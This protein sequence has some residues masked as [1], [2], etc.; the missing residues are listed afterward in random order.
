MLAKNRISVGEPETTSTPAEEEP[1]GSD[2]KPE[3]QQQSGGA[4][5][6][7]PADMYYNYE[8]LCSRATV[9]PDSEIPQN[10]LIL[11]HS[12]GYDSRRRSNLK[13]LDEST[14][15][16][17]AGNLLVLLDV[18][19]RKQ[20]YLRSFSGGGIGAMAVH[21]TREFF[22][23]AE[24]GAQ[25]NIVVYEYPSLRPY[26]LLRGG[27]ESEYKSVDFNLDGSLLASAGGAP[28]HRLTLWKWRQEKVMLVSEAMFQEIYRVSFSPYNPALLVSSG[29][30]HIKFWKMATTFTVVKLQGVIG[31]F[32]KTAATDI[33][34]Y[35]ELPDGKVVSG[36]GWGNLLLWERSTIWAEICR[37]EGGK[38]H[39]GT[40]Q[41]F[42][43]EDGQLMTF[44]SDGAIR[45]WDSELINSAD[46]NGD[47]GTFEMEP[48]NELVV[49]HN[50]CLVSV[51]R[52]AQ[53]D[54]IY[55]A[56][57]SNGAIWKLDLSFSATAADPECLFS[58]HSGAIQGLD[59]SKKSHLMAT[60]TLDRSV[61]VFDFLSQRELIAT[62]FNQGGTALSWA[63]PLVSQSGGL[64]VTGFEDGVVR[65]LELYDPQ[66]LGGATDRSPH[67]EAALRLRQAFKP[68]SAAVT[69]VAFD[70]SGEILATGSSDC[71]IF[72]FAV[73]EK[74]SPVGFVRVPGPVRALEWSPHSHRENRLLILCGSGDVV[75]VPGPDAGA[76]KSSKTF[77][78][79]HLPR[80]S[81]RF[82]SIK[83]RIKREEE[84][85]RREAVKKKKEEEKELP[86]IHIPNPPSPLC[87]GF[88]SQPGQFWLS[89][90]G[91]DA[92][93]LY[94]CK[95]SE[96]QEDD[97]LQRQDEPF[98]FRH[99]N[100]A[101][102]D[103]I[104]F[105]TFS[106]NRQLLLCGMQSGSIR[107]YPLQ[108]EDHSL[109]SMQAYWALS[110]HDN[111]YGHVSHVRCSVDDLFVLTGGGD[112]NIF[113]FCLLSP[114]EQKETLER[115]AQIPSPRVGLE[116]EPL[117]L[118][119]EDP[120]AYS[121][122]EAKQEA[123][124]DDQRRAAELKE[125]E[126]QR[127]LAELQRR[128]KKV[129]SVNQSLA[130]H[131]WLKAQE[132]LL[133][134]CFYKLEE[135]KSMKVMEVQ[136]QMAGE[137]ERHSITKLQEWFKGSLPTETV[138]VVGIISD[139]RVSNY[140][141]SE[142][143]SENEPPIRTEPDGGEEAAE[144]KRKPV[145]QPSPEGHQSEVETMLLPAV[146]PKARIKLADRQE[147]KL[148]QAAEQAEQAWANIE[149][150]R[151]EL[152]QIIA[153]KPEENATDSQ[154][155]QDIEEAKEG[156]QYFLKPEE[157]RKEAHEKKEGMNQRIL[158]LRDVKVQL[159]AQAQHLQEVQQG[160]LAHLC[161]TPPWWPKMLPEETPEKQL[162]LSQASLER[163]QTLRAQRMECADQ[164]E[165][166]DYLDSLEE[167][168]R[169]TKLKEE[170][171][172]VREEERSS[173]VA[174]EA[175]DDQETQEELTELE[176]EQQEEEDVQLLV[177]QN[178]LIQQMEILVGRFEEEL[179][180]L[181]CHKLHL[182]NWLKWTDLQ[183]LMLLQE[184]R[185]LQPL[186]EEEKTLQE[187]INSFTQEENNLTPKLEENKE[188]LELKRSRITKLKETKE[189]LTSEFKAS[190]GEAHLFR[191]FLISVFRKKV[192][193]EE[194][195]EGDEGE[196]ENDEDDDSDWGDYGDDDDDDDDDSDSM[197][198]GLCPKGCNLQLFENTL[199]LRQR[200][201]DVKQ[202]LAEEERAAAALK[203]ETNLLMRKAS[204]IKRQR[205]E[206]A[207]RLELLGNEKKQKIKDLDMMVPLKLKQIKFLS[208]GSI[209]S[210][211]SEAL[212]LDRTRQPLEVEN[213]Q[214]KDQQHQA[215][216]EQKR[217]IVDRRDMIA[218][219]KELEV[220]CNELQMGRF[221][222]PVDVETLQMLTGCRREEE[223][224]Q[225]KLL[226]EAAQA[227]EMK[228]WDE[229]FEEAMEALSAL[230]ET[231]VERL[232]GMTILNEQ[233][234]DLDLRFDA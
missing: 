22:C 164:G 5:Q 49:G 48:I 208:D 227:E 14:L 97:P 114:E 156:I 18:S 197:D 15:M 51:V 9:T 150:R 31:N 75:E 163:Y 226:L 16:F 121:L 195:K 160:R 65:L 141:L 182:D 82:R 94:H 44:G 20:R 133:D 3:T 212:V 68:H 218:C 7:L 109:T 187:K 217:L 228:L 84:I 210:D 32:G 29:S 79:H 194:E 123:K 73:G 196:E 167:L 145:N 56:Q 33:E 158:A 95:L 64:L 106:S 129:L 202:Q 229:K 219:I 225:E 221:G 137:Q 88:Y 233:R 231:N 43:L 204:E 63:P 98:A 58:F 230:M 74:Y 120:T 185:L 66:K 91:F 6:E 191:D 142:F 42:T 11:S 157:M 170:K 26:R 55:F 62:R 181:L 232:Y 52:S 205:Q 59:V 130:E 115:K 199:Q 118:D 186:Q 25:P 85:T 189:A 171:D 28:D 161:Q 77:E 183:L 93:F 128:Y 166:E 175:R 152:A 108:P 86:P 104:C 76:P 190:L 178:A 69:A 12:F 87:C 8:K 117:A 81:F 151:Q 24:K 126:R 112:G 223:L 207:D 47:S 144:E 45:A 50:V 136:K 147:Q 176:E 83:S 135:K 222:K 41:L 23:V 17:I 27:T 40:V 102:D 61:R 67:A 105:M 100:E 103:P 188:L 215:Q 19:T 213:I 148:R 13:L 90:G 179:L 107:A 99:V 111:Q 216:Q 60:T 70:R 78:L 201:L 119:I 110:I 200:L 127:Q 172:N 139:H 54:S 96:H 193:K 113:C 169:E 203:K 89:M 132:L 206:G 173:T 159:V 143:R 214:L 198:D 211:L 168:Q 57:D 21:P 174:A 184:R 180:Q 35:V 122:E 209:P 134:P 71:T 224:K 34:G 125:A 116:D 53:L 72:F 1:E 192:Q 234:K 101:D 124:R 46:I 149:R 2:N 138:S 153:E 165:Q 92:G 220:Q 155:D 140:S 131:I 38:C 162:Q 39:A 146:V 36:T 80:R 10:L 154:D 30:G 37:K 177:E 4:S